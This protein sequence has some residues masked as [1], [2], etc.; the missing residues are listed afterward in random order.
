MLRC[1]LE[2]QKNDIK[3]TRQQ[4]EEANNVVSSLKTEFELTKKSMECAKNEELEKLKIANSNQ[5]EE[6]SK[7]IQKYLQLLIM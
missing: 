4:L 3:E 1:E 7:V 2:N 5:E 6:I